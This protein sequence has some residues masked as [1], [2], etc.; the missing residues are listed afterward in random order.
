MTLESMT[1]FREK[2]WNKEWLNASGVRGGD[3]EIEFWD[4]QHRFHDAGEDR[5]ARLEMFLKKVGKRVSGE[6]SG[7][8]QGVQMSPET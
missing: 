7:S 3:A 2:M 1:C 8:L 4:K 5:D 6:F